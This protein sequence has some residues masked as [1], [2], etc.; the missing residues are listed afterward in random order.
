MK[1][2]DE[3]DKNRILFPKTKSDYELLK[4]LTNLKITNSLIVFF[5]NCMV[6]RK[7]KT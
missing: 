2:N 3:I 4:I 7:G 5:L 1:N 6:K